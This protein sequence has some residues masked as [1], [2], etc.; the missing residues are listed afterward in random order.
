MKKLF[1]TDGIRGKANQYPMTPEM[2]LSVGKAIAR[3]FK[4]KNDHLHKIVIGKDTRLSGYM[5]ETALTSGIVSQGVDVLLVGPMPTPAIAHLTRSLNADAG[6]VISASHN[7]ASDNGIKIFNSLGLKLSDNTE[8]EI[9]EAVF[10]KEE[11]KN[12]SQIGK[13][14][15]I[16]DAVGRYIE[17]AKSTVNNQSLQGLK[18]VLDC[19]NGA[20]YKTAPIIL[21]ELGAS[22]MT[23]NNSPDGQ[24]INKNCGAMFPQIIQKEV[25]KHKADIGIALD[26]DADRV[27]ICDEKGQIVDGDQIMAICA[28]ELKKQGKLKNNSV[29]T[30]IMSNLGFHNSMK[31]HGINALVTGVGD[32]FVIEKMLEQNSNFGGEQSGHIIFLDYNTTG[33]GIISSLQVLSI[34]KKRQ[35]K[36]SVLATCMKK[37][38]QTIVNIKVKE[39]KP[40]EQLKAWG[41]ILDTEKD[42]LDNGRILVR[43][44]GTENTCRVMIEGKNKKQIQKIAKEIASAIKKEIGD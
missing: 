8:H 37:L 11:H 6:I 35:K 33:D 42:L 30:T 4:K 20:A 43:Y 41:K 44:S 26:G 15:R 22:V 40:L 29:V 21:S 13:A 38:P 14:F 18:I 24:N 1:G 12:P 31:E 16:N 17:F 7:Q 39:K 23:L 27:I 9:E 5:I 32:R 36:L 28:T 2:A 25:K 19:A 10:S 34:M 3:V